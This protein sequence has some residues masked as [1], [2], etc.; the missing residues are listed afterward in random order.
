MRF[1]LVGLDLNVTLCQ[2]Q[3]T[4]SAVFGVCQRG[5]SAD[6]ELSGLRCSGSSRGEGLASVEQTSIGGIV[7]SMPYFG[8]PRGRDAEQRCAPCSVT[9]RLGEFDFADVFEAAVQ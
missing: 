2:L 9:C 1:C 7:R 6:G 8:S 4:L 5:G 3:M